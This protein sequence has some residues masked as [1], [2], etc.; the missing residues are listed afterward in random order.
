MGRKPG[1]E[2]QVVA[3]PQLDVASVADGDAPQPIELALVHPAALREEVGVLGDLEGLGQHR[4][5]PGGAL[6][7]SHFGLAPGR[8][9]PLPGCGRST[10]EFGASTVMSR[11]GSA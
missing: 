10:T 2:G 1:G 6:T 7:S 3:R 4:W 11:E 8:R 5:K 9:A